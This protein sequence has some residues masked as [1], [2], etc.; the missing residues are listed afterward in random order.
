M[1]HRVQLSVALLVA[2]TFIACSAEPQ[3]APGHVAGWSFYGGDAGGRRYSPLDQIDSAN[4]ASLEVA[5]QIRTGDLDADPPPPGHMAF[6]ATPILVDGQ[7]I[8][9]TP[10]GRI[11]SLDPETGE[12]LW[13]FEATV[14]EH[15]YPEFTSRGVASFVDSELDEGAPCH[16][17]IFAATVESRLFAIDVRTGLPCAGF[18]S[19][20]EVSLREGMDRIDTPWTFTISSPPVV[21]GD[22]VVVGSALGDNQRVEA[23]R[24]VV[25]AYDVHTGELEWL[26]DPIP[27]DPEQA[28]HEGWQ[29]EQARRTG[30]ANAWAPLSFDAE[31]D[32]LFVPTSSPS[33]DYYGGER[34]GSDRYA[35]SVVALRASTG[36][37]VWAFQLVHH[38]LWDYD[39]P[40]QPTLAHVRR[41]GRDVP[42]VVQTTKTGLV[43]VLHRETGEPVFP[44]EERPVPASDVPGEEAWPTQPFPTATARLVPNALRPEDVF[45]LTPYDRGK[46]RE[47]IASLRNEGMFTPPSLQGTLAYPGIAGGSNWGGVA[48]DPERRLIVANVTN[49][50]FEV[51]LIPR[52]DFERE[53]EVEGVLREYAPQHGTPYGIMREPILGPF[54][55]PCTPPPWGML[56][57]ISLD[58]GAEVWRRPFGAAPDQLPL[59]AWIEPGLPSLGGPIVTAGGVVLIGASMDGRFRAFDVET[60]EELFRDKLPAGGNAT[61]MT[62]RLDET[63]RQ[64][65]VIS[66]GG[67]G[68]LGTRRG[69]YVVAYALPGGIRE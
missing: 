30:A 50:A 45:G 54:F 62:Y 43:F 29:P 52:D 38:D 18:G 56:V 57:A 4:A 28:M 10:L 60:G 41:E 31:R 25:R 40:A 42:V 36:E 1:R 2:A 19:G 33:P 44:V 34:L 15:R 5:W 21:A 55:M 6:Q 53:R 68:K 26:W 11:L 47:R 27:A 39:T 63:G 12:E 49:L 24:G 22:L 7:L 46:C 69:D 66:A 13:R 65:V 67:H 14:R 23:P 32:L 20:G 35:N 58:T 17:R 51:R 64:Y 8:L 16:T 3:L 9:P 48:I 59:P 61:P 37:L